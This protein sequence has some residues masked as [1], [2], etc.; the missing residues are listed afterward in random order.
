MMKTK[1]YFLSIL[2]IFF[3]LFSCNSD[4]K[5]IDSKT[6]QLAQ[7]II[8]LEFSETEIDSMLESL[9]NYRE[10]YQGIRTLAIGN[11]ISPRLYFDPRPQQFNIPVEQ[12]N[13][14]WQLPE[15]VEPPENLEELAFYPV[16]KLAA[17]IKSRKITSVQLTE[18]YLKRLKKYGDT[19]QCVVR[20][21]E[22]LAL[23]QAHKADDEIAEG[24]YRGP[25]H[26][27]PYGVKDLFAVEGY[28]TTWGAAPY[29]NQQIEHTAT[30]VKQLEEAGAVLV[31]KLTLGALAM[32]D[33]WFGGVTK[34]PW[35][36]N[37]GSSG[38][39][40]GSASATAAGLVGFALGTETWGSIVSPSTRCGVTGL[41]PTFGRVSRFGAMALSWTMDKVG[42]IARNAYDC[43]LVFDVI[44][45]VDEKDP[46]TTNYPFNYQETK[47]T[48]YKVGYLKSYFE[49]EYRGQEN[50]SLTL[51][52][53]KELGVTLHELQLPNDLPVSALSIILEAEASAAFDDLTR[54]NRDDELTAQHQYAWPNIFRSARFIPAT[55][56]IQASR[57]RDMLIEELYQAIKEYDVIVTPSYGGD[58][59][60]MTN[61]T[62]NPCVVVPNGFDDKQH[63][64]SI[65]FFGNLYDEAAL[66]NF[67][68]QYQE[69]TDFHQQHPDFFGK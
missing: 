34:N 59:L 60:L 48:D 23:K 62:G 40:A 58:Q 3:V 16:S 46:S 33:V 65:S 17:L 45:G 19:L 43:A 5:E 4:H 32:G 36:L 55:E 54:S 15:N 31:A 30:V 26:G 25:L 57:V 20:L 29:K 11:E 38:S 69:A 24:I 14:R 35:D 21:T 67:V 51:D 1:I 6:I 66:L 39:S 42:P 37:Q 10:S 2:F 64:T 8:D 47:I 53:L 41:R 49:E 61:L 22:E 52:V 27:I 68:K 44:R 7:K 28:K 18:M 12:E 9:N 13:N 56:Y 63:P 50:D